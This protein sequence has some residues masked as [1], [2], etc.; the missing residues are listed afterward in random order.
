[1]DIRPTILT[2]NGVDLSSSYFKGNRILRNVDN[3]CMEVHFTTTNMKDILYMRDIISMSDEL[4]IYIRRKSSIVYLGRGCGCS[5]MEYVG[6]DMLCGSSF[7]LNVEYES[8][9]SKLIDTVSEEKGCS[10]YLV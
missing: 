6:C 9:V 10:I 3:E 4:E 1:M 5:I 7:V 8:E 2:I